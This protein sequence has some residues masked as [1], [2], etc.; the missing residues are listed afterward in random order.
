[1]TNTHAVSLDETHLVVVSG[2]IYKNVSTKCVKE[3]SSTERRS[4]NHQVLQI[5]STVMSR[6]ETILIRQE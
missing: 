5:F 1:M 3:E 6:P 4:Y 2:L